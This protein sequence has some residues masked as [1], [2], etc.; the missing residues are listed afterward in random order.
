MK[1]FVPIS[2][3]AGI[4][5][6][7]TACEQPN[8][9]V[10]TGEL[11]F[12]VDTVKFD[13][14]FINFRTPTERLY[15][16]NKSNKDLLVQRVWLES[17]VGSEFSLIVDGIRK[18]DVAEV[19]IPEDDSIVVFVSLKSKL[20]NN[21]A[22]EY[23]SFQIG[24]QVQRILIRAFVRDAYFLSARLSDQGLS[25][26]FFDKDTFLS[27][28]KP[29]IFDGPIVIDE[30][31]TVRVEAGAELYFTPYKIGFNQGSADESNFLFSTLVV[32]GTLI[33][34]GTR[35]KPV[36]FQ[37][38]RLDPE[39]KEEPA[40]WRGLRFTQSSKNNRI[41]HALIKN[42][43]IGIEVDSVSFDIQPRLTL[44]NTEIRNMSFYGIYGVGF[45]IDGL[46]NTPALLME[47]CLVHSC[48]TTF[49]ANGGGNYELYNCTF[50]NSALGG[51]RD[52]QIVLNNFFEDE[53]NQQVIVYPARFIFKNTVIWG[54]NQIDGNEIAPIPYPGST[55]NEFVLDHCLIQ[56]DPKNTFDIS[57]YLNNS[58][59]NQDPQFLNPFKMDY[60]LKKGSPL[61]NAGLDLSN[62]Y[63]DDFRGNPDSLRIPP[64]D[65]GAFEFFEK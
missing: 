52:P 55:F 15:V 17:G 25:G 41:Q 20:Q 31:V 13:S 63:L 62:R 14:I 36:I 18:D 11:R 50:D 43:V 27:A 40:Q 58:I 57:P 26:F 21:F 39:Y 38:S 12:S 1:Y 33:A 35:S 59:L 28:D 64:F 10:S 23:V 45:S 60:R 46:G 47:N 32:S 8:V 22:E 49:A 6:V 42:A 48:N 3:L 44:R 30:G 2:I 65:I 29:I 19:I 56:Y 37:G 5:L 24:E 34:E 7:I 53:Q 61:I 16:Y 9:T 54:R 4:I 51:R